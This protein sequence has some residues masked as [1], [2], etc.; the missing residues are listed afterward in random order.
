MPEEALISVCMSFSLS[1]VFLS[2]FGE[3]G[4]TYSQ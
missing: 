3:K 2:F 4:Q 1:V